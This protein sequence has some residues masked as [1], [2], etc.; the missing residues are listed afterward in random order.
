MYM[1]FLNK[2]LLLNVI[3]TKFKTCW[4]KRGISFIWK[5]NVSEM[6]SE[7]KNELNVSRMSSDI[8]ILLY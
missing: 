6:S 8:K 1:L 5:G 2:Y 7:N 3:Y 4:I